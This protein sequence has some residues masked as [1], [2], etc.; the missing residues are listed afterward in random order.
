M[1]FGQEEGVSGQGTCRLWMKGQPLT[2]DNALLRALS[3]AEFLAEI[4][5]SGRECC[6]AL[7]RLL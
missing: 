4:P 1:A 3:G 2:L 5:V 7:I 6:T